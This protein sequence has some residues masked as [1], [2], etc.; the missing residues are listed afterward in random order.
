MRR[1]F[2]QNLLFVIA[3][4]LLVKPL[5]IFMIDRTVQNKV[6]HADYGMYQALFNLGLVFQILLDFGINS[7][8][9][10]SLAENPKK[11]RLLFPPMVSARLALSGFYLI[12]VT[13]IGFALGY[14]GWQIGMLAGVLV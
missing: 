5:W 13:A 7:Y 9:S 2:A 1:F 3:V 10:K 6:G 12:A 8:N 14:R 11:I 4:N